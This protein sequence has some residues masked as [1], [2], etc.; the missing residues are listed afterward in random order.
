MYMCPPYPHPSSGMTYPVPS[1]RYHP[2]H[3]NMNL[4]YM[5]HQY[6][7]MGQPPHQGSTR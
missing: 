1:S 5:N 3:Q 6:P 4:P 7:Y 2:M